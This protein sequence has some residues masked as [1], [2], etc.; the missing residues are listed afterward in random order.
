MCLQ[1]ALKMDLSPVV[2][3]SVP[4]LIFQPVTSHH[5]SRSTLLFTHQCLLLCELHSS[6]AAKPPPPAAAAAA[7]SGRSTDKAALLH[8]LMQ[9]ANK[10]QK[11][12]DLDNEKQT[13]SHSS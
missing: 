8:R 4:L 10:G 13:D 2:T 7:A 12:N 1:L 6:A 9:M 3:A 5:S 11:Q